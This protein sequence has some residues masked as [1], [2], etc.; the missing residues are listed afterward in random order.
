MHSLTQLSREA[1]ELGIIISPILQIKK[2]RPRVTHWQV[3]LGSPIHTCAFQSSHLSPYTR[4]LCQKLLGV[5]DS[6]DP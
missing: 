6:P 4:C 3:E 2:L 1:H 5:G